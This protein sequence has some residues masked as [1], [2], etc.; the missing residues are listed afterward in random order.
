[1]EVVLLG[2]PFHGAH[3]DVAHQ[4]PYVRVGTALYARIDDPETGESLNAYVFD[5]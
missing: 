5:A 2:G 4:P 1:M 3:A